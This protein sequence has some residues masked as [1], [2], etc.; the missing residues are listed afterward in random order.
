MEPEEEEGLDEIIWDPGREGIQA[1]IQENTE[2]FLRCFD[3]WLAVQPDTGG[4]LVVGFRIAVPE[5][6]DPA[7]GARVVG[8][9]PEDSDLENAFMEGCVLGVFEGLRFSA[10]QDGGEVEVRYPLRFSPE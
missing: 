9:V 10:P 3:A 5:G 1:A 6:A 7:D 4:K 8:V 2:E